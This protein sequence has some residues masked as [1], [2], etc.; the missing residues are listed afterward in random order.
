MIKEVILCIDAF[1][2]C[3]NALDQVRVVLRVLR[4]LR[5]RAGRKYRC[6]HRGIFK[7]NVDAQ[8]FEP[9]PGW[10]RDVCE[11]IAKGCE[12]HAKGLEHRYTLR[13]PKYVLAERSGLGIPEA[14]KECLR[15]HIGHGEC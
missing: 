2:G 1:L 6:R 9:R 8:K 14:Q 11:R 4:V 3:N 10:V 5:V 15:F 7:R 13:L 12:D